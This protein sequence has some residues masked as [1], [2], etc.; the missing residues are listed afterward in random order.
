MPVGELSVH[1]ATIEAASRLRAEG[2]WRVRELEHDQDLLHGLAHALEFPD[3][4][5]ENWDAV[6][7]CLRDF[8][9]LQ[10]V[11]LLIL[12]A[13][14]RWEREPDAMR[15]LVDVWLHA[16]VDRNNDLHLVFVW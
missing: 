4:F 14:S 10:P 7:E 2:T 5:G 13:A 11:A 15:T 16:A 1:F 6:E 9:D 12:G 8:E 3:Y